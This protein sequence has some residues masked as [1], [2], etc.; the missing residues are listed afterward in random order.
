MSS[1]DQEEADRLS[2][3]VIA[4]RHDDAGR[5]SGAVLPDPLERIFGQTVLVGRGE[6]AIDGAGRQVF[7]CVEDAGV[8]SDDLL[9][10]IAVV[11]VRSL[12]PRENAAAEVLSDDRVLRR[13]LKDIVQECLLLREFAHGPFLHGD[14]AGGGEYAQHVPGRVLVDRAVVQHIGQRAAGMADGQRVVGDGTLREDLPVRRTRRIGL[15]EV[16]REVGPHQFVPRD[17]GHPDRRLVHVGD[18]AF[19]AD[20]HHQRVQAR[21]DQAPRVPLRGVSLIPARTAP[22]SQPDPARTAPRSQPDPECA[23]V[24]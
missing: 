3:C 13:T 5:E 14:V 20:H 8:S 17:P 18:L 24:R 1:T 19:R 4:P 16:V 6:Q 9:G 11:A 15:G 2:V 7:R 22:R 23:A 21:L 12:V 10:R